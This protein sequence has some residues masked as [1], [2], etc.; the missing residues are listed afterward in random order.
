LLSSKPCESASREKMAKTVHTRRF[1]RIL[2]AIVASLAAGLA[3]SIG[4]S[5]LWR[6]FDDAFACSLD[7]IFSAASIAGYG[8][9][10]MVVFGVAAGRGANGRNIDVAAAVLIAPVVAVLVYAI[11]RNGGLGHFLANF[12]RAA[13]GICQLYLPLCLTV[14]VQ[15][16]LVRRG[17]QTDHAQ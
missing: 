7:P 1:G 2:V 4:V 8:L 16:M 13:R 14:A 3:L 5:A 11:V 12:E 9:L 6:C 15:W 17:T 10:S